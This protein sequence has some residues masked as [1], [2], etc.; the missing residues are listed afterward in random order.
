MTRQIRSCARRAGKLHAMYTTLHPGA[1]LGGFAK[2]KETL[3]KTSS[4]SVD[5]VTKKRMELIQDL[6]VILSN[7]LCSKEEYDFVLSRLANEPHQ[8]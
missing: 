7:E 5:R 8:I 2:W 6:S 1:S 3:L 4:P